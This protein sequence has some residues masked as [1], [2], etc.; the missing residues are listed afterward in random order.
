MSL[1]QAHWNKTTRKPYPPKKRDYIT[2]GDLGTSFLDRYYKMNA[3][4]VTNDF[5]ERVLRIFDAGNVMEFIV[6]RAL[7]M[8]G[9]LNTKQTYVEI[10]ATEGRL[11]VM[12]YLDATIGGFADWDKAKETIERHLEEYKLSLDKELLE[13]KAISIIEGLRVAYPDGKIE[14]ML[15]EVK[16]INSM[17]FWAHKNRDKAGN[18]LGYDHNKMQAYGY[19][20]ATGLKK[21]LLLYISKDD[22]V[23]EEIGLILGNEKME[24]MFYKDVNTM[25]NYYLNDIVPPAEPEILW[26]DKKKCY[27]SNWKLERSSYLTKITGKEKEVWIEETGKKVRELNLVEKWKNQAKE[28]GFDVTGLTIEAI[29]KMCMARNRELNKIAKEKLEEK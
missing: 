17:A 11:K 2:F 25:S 27:E 4:P 14:E 1:I 7:A 24:E 13:Q 22:F 16:S 9:I 5:D 23:M 15:I 10:P 28:H 6:L 29:K 20:K 8:A 21:G 18:F 26:N 19:M 3:E 12:G